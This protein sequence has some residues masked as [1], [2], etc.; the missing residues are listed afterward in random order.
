[1]NMHYLRSFQINS[2]KFLG[3]W[4][5]NHIIVTHNYC[6]INALLLSRPLETNQRTENLPII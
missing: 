6:E 5:Q 2:W 3:P 4:I 1:M